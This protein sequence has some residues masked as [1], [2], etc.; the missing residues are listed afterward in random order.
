MRYPL[1]FSTRNL[2]NDSIILP[3]SNNAPNNLSS[4]SW[5]SL[6][7]YFTLL[8]TFQS[9]KCHLS[10]PLAQAVK[11]EMSASPCKLVRNGSGLR[12]Y[13]SNMSYFLL[14]RPR[15]GASRLHQ[16][17]LKRMEYF[18]SA[19]CFWWNGRKRPVRN[20]A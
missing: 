10:A 9:S 4:S 16:L 1:I 8:A 15:H 11:R 5:F 20:R 6:I 7:S 13:Y 2:R 3:A 18:I 12:L 17:L 14:G 19:L